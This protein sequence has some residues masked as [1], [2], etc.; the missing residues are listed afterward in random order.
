MRRPLIFLAGV[1]TG[2]VALIVTA[3]V[4]AYRGMARVRL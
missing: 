4:V 2:S 3:V 1:A